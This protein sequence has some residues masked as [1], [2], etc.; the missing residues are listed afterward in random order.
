MTLKKCL[1]SRCSANTMRFPSLLFVPFTDGLSLFAKWRKWRWSLRSLPAQIFCERPLYIEGA[2]KCLLILIDWLTNW[3]IS[4]IYPNWFP[5][6]L[7]AQ[8]HQVASSLT[9]KMSLG[10]ASCHCYTILLC[11]HPAKWAGFWSWVFIC[12][13]K[14]VGRRLGACPYKKDAKGI[15]S[16]W[17]EPRGLIK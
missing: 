16:S 6:I 7:L 9:P 8:R 5:G 14:A 1:E 11:C 17:W 2:G 10:L 13:R 4:I 12:Q 3:M 15:F